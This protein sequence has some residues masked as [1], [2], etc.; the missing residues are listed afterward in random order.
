MTNNYEKR[1]VAYLDVLG[2]K[3]LIKN[4]V[5]DSEALFRNI[6]VLLDCFVVGNRGNFSSIVATKNGSSEE[7]VERIRNEICTTGFSDCIVISAEFNNAGASSFIEK[8]IQLCSIAAALGFFV[9]GG[10][11]HG[12]LYHKQEI[13]F[14]PAFI[15]AYEIEQK[16]AEYYRVFINTKTVDEIKKLLTK[17]VDEC[18]LKVTYDTQYY[19]LNYIGLPYDWS[20]TADNPIKQ[21][22][23]DVYNMKSIDPHK[24]LDKNI[25]FGHIR[26]LIIKSVV[27]FQREQ[28]QE[29]Y[30]KL[31]EDFNNI[32]AK[33]KEIPLLKINDFVYSRKSE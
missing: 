1:L 19:Y 29:K 15:E 13:V 18:F 32:C 24:P 31:F 17:N 23:M 30:S 5:P 27:N 21:V 26:N 9:R 20:S 2:F 28:I 11:C 12:N 7:M 25:W 16:R 10:I 4:S 22:L 8:T 33:N 6:K 14:G 3:E